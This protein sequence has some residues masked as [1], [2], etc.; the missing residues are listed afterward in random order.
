MLIISGI[1]A[2]VEPLLKEYGEDSIEAIILNK[3]VSSNETFGYNSLN[4]LKFEL[5]MRKNIISASVELNDGYMKFK[6][7]KE[8]FCN[9]TYWELTK[10]GG[11][12][13]KKDTT[14]SEGISDIFK[15][16]SKYGTECS[17]AIV[18]V[19]YR[20]ILNIFPE[21]LF[22]KTFGDILLL[23]WHSLDDDLRIYSHE[24]EDT[25]L[26]GDCLYFENPDHDPKK[27]EWQGE[28]VIDLGNGTYYGH[29]IGIKDEKHIVKV[30]NKHRKS[31]AKKEA[32]LTK[33]IARPNFKHLFSIY[34][35]SLE[36][37]RF[38]YL[39]TYSFYRY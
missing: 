31:G 20:A 4:Q 27:Q 21:E 9:E 11:F 38:E 12:K 37:L 32:Y 23:N 22:N 35:T 19:Y 6:T 8:A 34:M 2:G 17:T 5:N 14:A 10:E 29:G 16:S 13:L 26:P 39:R 7:F 36:R 33:Y 25:Y 28:N 30:L 3:M 24:T 1:E 18:I 15:H